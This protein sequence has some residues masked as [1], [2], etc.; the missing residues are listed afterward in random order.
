MEIVTTSTSKSQSCAWGCCIRLTLVL[1]SY[2]TA[3]TH[4][5]TAL[6]ATSMLKMTVLF[7]AARRSII[8]RLL[9][10]LAPQSNARCTTTTRLP[11]TLA[12]VFRVLVTGRPN[13]TYVPHPV[14]MQQMMVTLPATHPYSLGPCFALQC[15]FFWVTIDVSGQPV[16]CATYDFVVRDR[17]TERCDYDNHVFLCYPKGT[18]TVAC[19]LAKPSSRGTV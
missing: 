15:D 7:I 11:A 3:C 14:N 18:L 5:D 9:R 12:T 6:P 13:R 10:I 16:P 4:L 8:R 19:S 2:A 17:P 1:K